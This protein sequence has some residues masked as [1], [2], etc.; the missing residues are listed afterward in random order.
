MNKGFTFFLILLFSMKAWSQTDTVRL[1]KEVEGVFRCTDPEA[2]NWY[3]YGQGDQYILANLKIPE[4]EVLS[5]FQR[6]KNS[7]NLY[8]GSFSFMGGKKMLALNKQDQTDD[9]IHFEILDW[10][11]DRLILRE[12]QQKTEYVFE[13]LLN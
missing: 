9:Y 11:P 10:Q 6:F 3:I 5:W 2:R 4:K 13:K 12:L 1:V 8:R 7:Q